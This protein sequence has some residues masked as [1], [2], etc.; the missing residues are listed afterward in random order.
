[1]VPTQENSKLLFDVSWE[2][3][4]K[5]GGVHSVLTTKA[6]LLVQEFQNQFISIGP[7]VYRE[8]EKHPEFTEDLK[9]F[10]SWRK[11]AAREGLRVRVGHWNI[12]SRPVVIIVDFTPFIAQK[13]EILAYFWEKFQVDSISGGW[14]YVEPVLFGYA[15]GKVIESFTKYHYTLNTNVIAHFQEWLTGAGVLYLKDKAPYIATTY[16]AHDTIIGR[17]LAKESHSL[18][19]GYADINIQEIALKQN[20]VSKLSIEKT[21]AHQADIFTTVSSI[22]AQECTNFLNKSV[23]LITPNGITPE[24]Y[25]REEQ[26]VKFETARKKLLSIAAAITNIPVHEDALLISHVGRNDIENEG[27]D[28]FLQSVEHLVQANLVNRPVIAFCFVDSAH[29]GARKEVVARIKSG[30]QEGTPDFP[31]ISHGLHD[32]ENHPIFKAIKNIPYR[33]DVAN[34]IQLVFIPTRLDGA[35]GIF[36][37]KYSDII[38][39]FDLT[40]YPSYYKPWGYHPPESLSYAVPTLCTSITG[41]GA[42]IKESGIPFGDALRVVERTDTNDTQVVDEIVKIITEFSSKSETEIATA[43]N[44]AVE[45]AQSASWQELIKYIKR[46]YN[47]ALEKVEQRKESFKDMQLVVPEF[48]KEAKK[49]YKAPHWHEVTV[50]AVIPESLSRLKELSRNIWWT[51]NWEAGELFEYMNPEVWTETQQNPVVLLDSIDLPRYQELE[52]DADFLARYKHVLS[53]FDDYMSQAYMNPEETIAYFSMEF[54][55]HDSIKIYSGGLGILAGDYLK[56]ASDSRVNM[57]GIGLLY[58][59]GYFK[60]VLSMNGEQIAEYPVQDFTQLPLLAVCDE[61]GKELRISVVLPGRTV[62]AKIW[63]LNVGRIK[64]FLLDT[65]LDENLEADRTIT[66]AL[67]GGENENRLKQEMILGVGGIRALHAMNKLPQLYHCN[68]GHAAFIGLE[69]LRKFI[70]EDNLSFEESREI[71]RS[72]T[73]F[74]TH[75]PVPAGHD[76]FSEDLLR[77]YMSHYPFRL[78]ISWREFMALGKLNPDDTE[79]QFSMSVLALNLSQEVNGVSWLHGEVSKEMFQPMFPGYFT[80]ELHISYVTNGVHYESWTAPDWQELYKSTFGKNFLLNQHKQEHWNHIYKVDDKTIWNIHLKQ[81]KNLI[82]YLKKR[83]EA[84]WIR[85]HENPHRIT[86]VLQ[87][88][89]ENSLIIGF[90]RRFATYKRAYLLFTDIERLDKLINQSGKPVLFLFAGK[91]HPKDIPGQELIKKVVEVS[92]MPQFLGKIL[93]LENYEIG[94]AKRLVQGVDIWMNTPTRPLEASGTSGMKAVMN[95]GLH[96]SVLDGWWVEGYQKDAGWALPMERTYDDQ[97]LQNNLDAEMIYN[98]FESEILPSYYSFNAE[99]VPVEWVKLMKNSIAHVAPKFTMKRMIEDYK[100]RFY[101]KLYRRSIRIQDN[102]HELARNIAMWKK[103]VLRSWPAVSAE[104]ILMPYMNSTALKIGLKYEGSV[105]LNIGDLLP[106]DIGVELVIVG[107]DRKGCQMIDTLI[108][109]KFEKNEGKQAFFILEFTPVKPG[110]LSYGIRVY[111]NNP[112]LP[113]RQDFDLVKW[114]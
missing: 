29:Y 62:Y 86:E 13:N 99:H 58:R 91:A 103:R 17:Y 108:P 106:E 26:Q 22:T 43:R 80:D 69:R 113:H 59:S 30:I 78:K 73:L 111:A 10:S 90:A 84:H 14:D 40:L 31:F 82:D 56:E 39:G 87:N 51:W 79:E 57:T 15:S 94:L 44:H 114:F 54:G 67:Y 92:R 61:K 110:S 38:R 55:F 88:L 100:D 104:E 107:K 50:H 24:T 63:Q 37:V 5:V 72:S 9:L 34:P 18:Y 76:A 3:C 85:R 71:I 97:Q 112:E 41:F 89:N 60:Q 64:L 95:G 96:F 101:H 33:A 47:Y 49:L 93:F 105:R 77:T 16:T 7:D 11:Q 12:P 68:E 8:T 20:L 98:I 19:G 75:T 74:T 81:K 45:I 66:Y 102:E 70:Y 42:W 46:A 4:N 2:V 25:S 6:P 28:I 21:A 109:F 36:N 1:M 65:D 53:L 27:I 23:D 48:P 83:V 52:K 32:A 35:D